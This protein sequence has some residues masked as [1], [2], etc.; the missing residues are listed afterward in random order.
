MLFSALENMNKIT[1]ALIRTKLKIL[2]TLLS[3][4]NHCYQ[5]IFPKFYTKKVI[6]L[7]VYG[8]CLA[9]RFMTENLK[10]CIYVLKWRLDL[11]LGK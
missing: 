6:V 9:I 11:A 3:V 5:F 8:R 1:Q 2:H 10:V 7:Q 4:L